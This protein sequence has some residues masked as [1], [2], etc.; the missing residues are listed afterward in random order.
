MKTSTKWIITA[1]SIIIFLLACY[2]AYTLRKIIV[3]GTAYKAKILCSGIFVSKRSPETIIDEDLLADDLAPLRHISTTVDYYSHSVTATFFGLAKRKAIYRPGLGCTLVIGTPEKKLRSA[4]CTLPIPLRSMHKDLPWPDGEYIRTDDI[5][6]EINFRYL[7]T[8]ID[9]AF[10]EPDAARL[11][12]TRAV[13]IVYNSRII[14]ERYAPG[15]SCSTPLIGWTMTGSVINALTGILV[16]KGK[17]SLRDHNLVP[18]WCNPG[19]LRGQITL[20]QLLRMTS[21]LSG[22]ANGF[23]P[24]K[25]SLGMLLSTG[26]VAAHAADMTLFATPGTRWNFSS[27]TTNIISGILRR[28]VEKMGGIYCSFPKRSLFNKIGMSTAVIEPDASGTFVGSSFMYAS[29]RDWARFGLLY[30][31]DG[32]WGKKRILPEGWVKYSRKP[33]PISP[34]NM[35]GAHFWL[36]IPP[37]YKT[38]KSNN[39]VLPPDTFHAVGYEGQFITIIPSHK[40]VIVRLGLTR[41]RGA[42]DHRLFVASILKAVSH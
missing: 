13:V 2:Y 1:L 4:T 22:E 24:Y 32:L 7:T 6:P 26:D 9:D 21:G 3:I 36:E 12:R 31:Q 16:G 11:R 42:W 14:A 18:K 40:L 37:F 15:F 23:G 28:T 34:H 38:N 17:L 25:G 33:T 39:L 30:L 35:Y 5:P 27:E 20:N 41:K 10:V 8:I 19:D 29:A